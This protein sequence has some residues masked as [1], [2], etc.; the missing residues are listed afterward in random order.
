MCRRSAFTLIELLVVI[1]IIG[2]MVGLLLPAV[3][4]VRT[5]A[6][7]TQCSNNLH[8]IGLATHNYHDVHEYFPYYRISGLPWTNQGGTGGPPL[9]EDGSPVVP[10]KYGLELPAPTQW[11]GKNE[12]WWAPYDN[13]PS[14][15][16]PTNAVGQIN[17]DNSYDH[18]GYPAGFLWPYIEQNIKIFQCPN[19]IDLMP[20]SATFTA[21]FQCSYAMNYVSGGPSGQRLQVVANGNGSANVMFVWDHAKTPGCADSRHAVLPSTGTTK[22]G[23]VIYP[24]GPRAPWPFT[25]PVPADPNVTA[26]TIMTHYP[27]VRHQEMFNV[28]YCDGHVAPMRQIDLKTDMFLFQGEVPFTPYVQ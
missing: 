27:Q 9:V 2:I 15:S 10:D 1:A 5:A 11:T 13:R 3:Q 24:N 4:A 6:Q 7:R 8:Q 16:S 21:P 19:G 17:L 12:I 22:T 26:A 18:G 25:P 20:G 14:P 28:L 23:G